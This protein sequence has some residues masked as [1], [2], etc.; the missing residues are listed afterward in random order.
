MPPNI[1]PSLLGRALAA[2]AL[3][4]GFYT[5][6]LGIAVTL[7]A[8]PIALWMSSGHGNIFATIA[9]AVAGV[10]ILRAL[11]PSRRRFVAPG[12]ELTPSAQPALHAEL[13]AVADAVGEPV[14]TVY[15]DADVNAGVVEVPAG[16]L[17]GR[18][19]VMLLGLPLLAA[20]TPRQLRAVVAHE[21]G[22]YVGGDT[23]LSPWIWRTRVAVLRTV[24]ALDNED[25][26][27]Q[28][29]VVRA[30]FLLYAK[31]F[32]RLTNAISRREEFAADQ[33]AVRVAGVQAN[34]QTLRA[35]TAAAPAYS[36]YWR[37]DVAYALESGHRPPIVAGFHRF[38]ADHEIR[39]Q[40]DTIV[41]AE[42]AEGE[43]D[44][45]DSHPTL[46][47][48]LRA[49]GA[50]PT[51][52]VSPPA[53]QDSAAA[54]LRDLDGLERELLQAT[55]GDE[56]TAHLEPIDW[57]QAGRLHADEGDA[58]AARH[59]AAFTRLTIADV[60]AATAPDDDA[61][62][63]LRSTLGVG[64][65]EVG[66]DE[67]NGFWRFALGRLVLAALRRDGWEIESVPGQ[68][69][70]CH[71]GEQAV[72]PFA[73]I[74]RAR[75]DPQ[76]ATEWAQTAARLGIAP[77]ALVAQPGAVARDPIAAPGAAV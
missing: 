64:P 54:L 4:V 67:L 65:D 2:I 3:T 39:A 48:R 1:P 29:V 56:V 34:A 51:G 11:V 61:L 8:G 71:R 70:V 63:S 47:D 73:A 55:F 66:I 41:A 36:A 49:I 7:L 75:Q 74:D 26:W 46:A 5:L 25:S 13:A 38:L 50:E 32:L 23:R 43:T 69:I 59:G 18:R 21:Y 77:L 37:D 15:L 9:L 16:L 14:P 30:P 24:G 28:R 62:R 17:G 58:I 76:A 45:Y 35:L 6:A 20:L 31:L 72:E 12:P 52:E 40:V 27:F 33:V 42:I 10:T 60:A 57:A 44:P 19:R 68:A 53:P 22:H